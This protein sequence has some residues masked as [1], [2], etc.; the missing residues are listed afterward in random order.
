MEE[1]ELIR[2]LLDKCFRYLAVRPR[3]EHEMRL[4]LQKRKQSET[5][6]EKTM[7]ILKEK[8]F[9]NDGEFV[10][11]WVE[12]RSF[13]K[14][15][16]NILLKNELLQKG[17]NKDIIAQVLEDKPID[18]VEL[19]KNA[20]VS[21]GKMLSH[22]RDGEQYKKAISFLQRRGFSYTVSKKAFEEWKN[23]EYNTDNL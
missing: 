15:K 2:L 13:H 17:V 8:G 9:V 4:Y 16:G 3:S 5:I 20:L 14:Q 22:F 12:Q 7:V 23:M 21:K 6:I 11:W 19:A 1:N 18:E 10:T